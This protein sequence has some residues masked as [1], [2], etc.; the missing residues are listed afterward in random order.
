[1][2]DQADQLRQLVRDTIQADQSLQPGVPIIALS[3]GKGGVGTTTIA[4]RLAQELSRLGKNTVLVDANLAQPDLAKL[5]P[6]LKSSPVLNN[7]Q[8]RDTLAKVLDGSRKAV[9]VLQ[10][11]GHNLQLLPGRWIP[12]SPPDLSSQA[13]DRL[14]AELRSLGST[15]DVV[16]ADVGCGM[17]P[18][19]NRLWQASQ[20]ILLVTTPEPVAVMDSYAAI[21]Q[22]DTQSLDQKLRIVVNR[23]DN[24]AEARAIVGRL[25]HTCRRFLGNPLS[26]GSTIANRQA[27][28]DEEDFEQSVRLLAAEVASNTQTTIQRHIRRDDETPQVLAACGLAK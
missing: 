12:Q 19:A 18:W 22:T 4:A 14:L 27:S 20:Q 5:F 16:V 9:E 11:V 10:S 13:V 3:G 23:C 15:A 7:S 2:H 17:S 8:P 1:M 26:H 21:K 28:N 6:V 24:K 25:D